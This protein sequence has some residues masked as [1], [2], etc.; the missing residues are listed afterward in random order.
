MVI[1]HAQAFIFVH[2]AKCGGTTITNLLLPRLARGDVVISSRSPR[3]VDHPVSTFF[4]KAPLRKLPFGNAIRRR[5]GIGGL[6]KHS[7]AS[8]IAQTV[9]S[10]IWSRYYSFAFVRNPWDRC[11]SSFFWI[12]KNQGKGLGI[13]RV[14]ALV[15]TVA[16]EHPDFATFVRSKEFRRLTEENLMAPVTRSLVDANGDIMVSRVAKL[17]ELANVAADI[18]PLAGAEVSSTRAN[19][20]RRQQDFSSYFDSESIDIVAEVYRSDIERFDYTFGGA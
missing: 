18:P 5:R 14:R 6:A 10:E 4:C 16:N 9:G 13:P 15:K 17:E 2:I 12:K 19:T 11:V 20:S 1:S 3:F 7:P 8:A